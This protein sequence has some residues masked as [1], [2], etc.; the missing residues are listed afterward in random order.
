[1]KKHGGAE[2]KKVRR[3]QS[4]QSNTDTPIRVIHSNLMEITHKYTQF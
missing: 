3:S 4:L 2:K 1:M